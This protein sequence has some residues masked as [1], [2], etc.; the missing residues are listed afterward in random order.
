MTP[1][2]AF[3]SPNQP[4]DCQDRWRKNDEGSNQKLLHALPLNYRPVDL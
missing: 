2:K 4:Y 1:S 3:G